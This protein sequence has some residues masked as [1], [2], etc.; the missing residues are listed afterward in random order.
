MAGLEGTDN[1]DELF[2]ANT[3]SGS[4]P[5][6]GAISSGSS[7]NDEIHGDQDDIICDDDDDTIDSGGGA[8]DVYHTNPASLTCGAGTN[9]AATATSLPM[10]CEFALTGTCTVD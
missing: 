5:D 1:D 9:D 6:M 10:D 3:T 2:L 4:P 8:D 7:G